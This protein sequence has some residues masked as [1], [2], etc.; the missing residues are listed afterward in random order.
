MGY[1]KLYGDSLE[2]DQVTKKVNIPGAGKLNLAGSAVTAT[3]AELNIIASS[4]A[5]NA[6]L[7]KLH[8]VSA[9]AAQINTVAIPGAVTLAAGA[10]TA[11]ANG[12]GK[13]NV[14][15]AAAGVAM[16]L[17]LATGSGAMFQI[18]VRTIVATSSL[19]FTCA[20]SDK[21]VGAIIQSK[22]ATDIINYA[23]NGSSNTTVTLDGSTK[24]GNVGDHLR[25]IDV[26]SGL[27]YVD[28]Y[29]LATGTVASPIS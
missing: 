27:W 10:M 11:A 17:P 8:A 20:G 25:F 14:H 3:A 9:T 13:I 21:L 5:T 23:A 6:D 12:N 29:T 24:G 16:T 2:I 4:G 15:S 28:G 19:T 1:K 18:V 7:I 22:S 26:A